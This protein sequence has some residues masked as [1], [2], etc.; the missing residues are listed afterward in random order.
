[1]ATHPHA[2][3]AGAGIKRPAIIEIS[4]AN[5]NDCN[6]A[7]TFYAGL[8]GIHPTT[9]KPPYLFVVA[10]EVSFVLVVSDDGF[11]QTT[12]FW[13]LTDNTSANLAK[14]YKELQDKHNCRPIKDKGPHKPPYKSLLRDDT[15]LC[16]LLDPSGSMFGL[17]INPPVP[18]I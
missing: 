5:D 1:M 16:S 13:E 7:K 15:E 9:T 2:L 17:V 8:L 3:F 6:T 12:I 10:V 14:V 4:F 18:V 11:P